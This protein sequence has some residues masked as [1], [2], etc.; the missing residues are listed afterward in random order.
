MFTVIDD[1]IEHTVDASLDGGSVDASLD[2]GS[3]LL[4]REALALLGWEL[5]PEGLCREGVCVPVPDDVTLERDGRIDLA[6]LA[7]VLDRP[8]AIDVEERAAYLGVSAGERQRA[9]TSL[10]APDFALPD[11]SGKPHRLSDH[12]G[13]KVLLVAYASW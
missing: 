10:V 1:G 8:L 5:H 13:K 12:R 3:V 7:R 2:G 9:L 4:A 6:A 11:L